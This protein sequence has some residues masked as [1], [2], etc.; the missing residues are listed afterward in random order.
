M[1][2]HVEDLIGD[3]VYDQGG[4][5][6]GKVKR[7]YVDNASGA[8]TWA[9]VSTGLFSEDSLVPL[10]GAQL[11]QDPAELQVRVRKE[12]V[13]TAPHLAHDGL[14]TQDSEN[15]LFVHYGVDPNRA[16]WED[17]GR[18]AGPPTRGDARTTGTAGVTGT[19]APRPTAP[20]MPETRRPDFLVRSEERLNIGTRQ[21]VSG[22]ARLHKYVVSEEQTI[23]V[24]TSHEEVHIEREPIADTSALPA[25]FGEQEQ[26]VTLHQDR[27]TVEK[28]MVP[29]ERVRLVIDQVDEDQTITETVRKERIEIEGMDREDKLR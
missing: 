12:A 19:A 4:A 16:G 25:D 13:K 21:E 22:H 8:P 27:V 10:A 1:A 6:I 26:E 17:Y 23:T 14:I 3:A 29:V 20:D 5:K 24:P 11:R 9:S 18:H 28:E 7:V 15:D 2:Q